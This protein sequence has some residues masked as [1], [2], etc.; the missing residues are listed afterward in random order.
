MKLHSTNG[1][2]C[3]ALNLMPSYIASGVTQA[4]SDT[5]TLSFIK[6]K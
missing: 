6:L 2:K 4:H 3:Y 1:K 5:P